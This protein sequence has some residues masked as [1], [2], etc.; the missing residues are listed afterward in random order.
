MIDQA[1]ILAAGKGTR[2]GALTE[3][4]PKPLLRIGGAPI[5]EHILRGLAE[6]GMRRVIIVIGHLGEQIR[7]CFS[8]GAGVGLGITYLPQERQNGTAKAALLARS[9]LGAAPFV[10]SFGDILCARRNYR[11]LLESFR[12]APCDALLGL[13]PVD[14]PWEGAA[15]YRDGDRVTKI[16]EKPRRGTSSTRW[17]NA[18]VMVLTPMLWPILDELAPSPRGEYE[19]PVGI[20][21]MVEMGFDVRG[22]EFDGFWSDVGRREELERINRIAAEGALDLS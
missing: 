14:D 10:M 16:I 22:V 18:G 19:L 9:H 13:N 20:G 1:L 12:S 21:R 4:C 2:M 5:L 3:T 17:N 15:V 7:E 11:R 8:A 6:V